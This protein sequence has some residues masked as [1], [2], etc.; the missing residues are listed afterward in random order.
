[1]PSPSPLRLQAEQ[2][3]RR[4]GRR[5]TARRRSPPRRRRARSPR[6]GAPQCATSC[7]ASRSTA[8]ARSSALACVTTTSVDQPKL[9]M[10]R[11]PARNAC[12]SLPAS[13]RGVGAEEQEGAGHRPFAGLRRARDRRRCPTGR[14]G[15]SAAA[16]EPWHAR[17][18][19]EPGR[20]ARA[21][22]RRLRRSA[23]ARLAASIDQQVAVVGEPELLVA[24]SEAG[25]S[26]QR[27]AT[28]A[29][30]ASLHSWKPGHQV[31]R[32]ARDDLAGVDRLEAELVQRAESGRRPGSP[33]RIADGADH[34]G[35]HQPGGTSSSAT[36]SGQPRRPPPTSTPSMRIAS[37]QSKVIGRSGGAWAASASASAFMPA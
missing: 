30:P 35:E 17:R 7:S 36:P 5:A 32:E 22:R 2:R 10:P 23:G 37:G 15:S 33:A 20:R 29:K 28:G 9:S 8:A 27:L 34:A 16:S 26:S 12:R 4:G 31:A 11:K 19:V 25:G 1:M 6:S 3:V 13:W 18:R 21:P 14:G 24:A